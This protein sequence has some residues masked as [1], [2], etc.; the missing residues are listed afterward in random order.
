[1]KNTGVLFL[2]HQGYSFIDDLILLSQNMGLKAF[3]LSSEIS[4]ENRSRIADLKTRSTVF[5]MTSTLTLTE[6][7]VL[8]FINDLQTDQ[9]EIVACMS[10][11]EGYRL[12]MA[13]ANGIL[14]ATDLEVETLRKLL[15][16]HQ[17]RN[18]LFAHGLS[19]FSSRVIVKNSLPPWEGNPMFIKPLSGLGSFAAF[20]WNGEPL[21]AKLTPLIDEMKTD[22]DYAGVFEEDPQFVAEEIIDGREYSFEVIVDRGLPSILAIH[23]KIELE[24]QFGSVLENACAGVPIYLTQEQQDQGIRFIGNILKVLNVNTGCFHIEARCDGKNWEIIEVNP[25]IGGAYIY[26]ST[27]WI[28]GFCLLKRWLLTLMNI[29]AQDQIEKYVAPMGRSF[30]RVYFGHPG[31]TICRIKKS[32]GDL[33]P[34]LSRQIITEGASLPK[35]SREIFVGQALWLLATDTPVQQIEKL[36]Q[37]S[38]KFMEIEYA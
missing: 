16:K 4:A 27:R 22:R 32:R 11:W 2:I 29:P 21:E 26:R 20:Q 34:N 3:V 28:S 35:S 13:K 33:E 36:Q 14:G 38:L 37:D 5:R 23:E 7:D 25:R 24:Q 12:Y 6:R 31:K 8:D 1:M 17:M 30:F 10:V 9:H 19:K 18:T 15:D